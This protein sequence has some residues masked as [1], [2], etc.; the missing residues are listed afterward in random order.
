[1]ERSLVDVGHSNEPLT[2]GPSK[3]GG[4]SGGGAWACHEEYRSRWSVVEISF[5]F[6]GLCS[7]YFFFMSASRIDL[8]AG[9]VY[10]MKVDSKLYIS[11]CFTFKE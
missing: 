8:K 9:I 2:G 4:S 1:M 6:L 11:R 10:A 5:F 7:F 3:Y